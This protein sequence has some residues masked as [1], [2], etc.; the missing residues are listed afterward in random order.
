MDLSAK[1]T[2]IKYTPLLCKSLPAYKFANLEQALSDSSAFILDIDEQTKVAVSWWVSPKRTRTYPYARVY[3]TLQFAGKRV[4]IIPFVKDE[5]RRGDRDFLQ[6]DTVSLMSLLG[7]YVIIS[8]YVSANRSAR[9]ENKIANQRFELNHIADKLNAVLSYQSDALHWNLAQIDRVAE[10]AQLALESYRRLS[11]RLNVEMHSFETF[12]KRAQKLQE[13]RMQ[14]MHMSRELAR[15]A[16]ERESVTI[17][18]KELL[19]GKKAKITIKNYLGGQYFLTLDELKIENDKA[20]LIEA[21]HSAGALP[22]MTDIKDG[23][24]KMFLFT[25]LE[26]V[27]IGARRYSAIPVLKLTSRTGFDPTKLSA[28]LNQ[29]LRLLKREAD[30]NGFTLQLP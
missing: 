10:T 20:Y 19:E 28:N 1:I 8:H 25:N 26:N 7:I 6:W 14:F 2:G 3:D 12:S 11:Q 30:E 22:S 17:Q 15:A 29:K 16:Q 21:K 4:T 24:I 23:L 27:T 18:P 5:G 13:G 9:Y